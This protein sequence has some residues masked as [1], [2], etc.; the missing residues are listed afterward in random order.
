MYCHGESRHELTLRCNEQFVV[1]RTA[2]HLAETTLEPTPD[3]TRP[4]E[5]LTFT[6]Q[7]L[8]QVRF[9]DA[10]R[11]MEVLSRL[12]EVIAS[13]RDPQERDARLVA[14]VLS[15]IRAAEA[16]AIVELDA[17][18]RVHVGAW[19]RRVETAGAFRPSVR[20][21][22]DGLERRR[23]R[24]CTSGAAAVTSPPNTRNL[25]KRTGPSARRWRGRT[26]GR[27]DCT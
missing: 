8:E 17:A 11:R 3:A 7:Q 10:D 6:R 22:S 20:L 15:G 21:V 19:E 27:G 2:F 16:V 26:V 23:G 25:R 14:L 4:L 13:A 18:G 24:R 5:V 1:G 12:P 9:G